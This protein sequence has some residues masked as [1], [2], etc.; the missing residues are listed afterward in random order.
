M[1]GRNREVDIFNLSF[2]DVLANGLGAVVTLLL[3]AF[4]SAPAATDTEERYRKVSD[5]LAKAAGEHEKRQIVIEALKE[6]VK[7]LKVQSDA[8]QEKI[9]GLVRDIGSL[10]VFNFVGIRTKKKNILFL[11]DLSGSMYE[12]P[13]GASSAELLVKVSQSIIK[14]LPPNGCRFN[15]RGFRAPPAGSPLQPFPAWKDDFLLHPATPANRDLAIEAVAA[16]V[17]SGNQGG[18]PTQE[19][20]RRAFQ[21]AS[22]E[23]IIL[24]TDGAPDGCNRR[25]AATGRTEAVPGEI[26]RFLGWVRDTRANRDIEVHC[27]GMGPVLFTD[28]GFRNFLRRLADQNNGTFA[29]F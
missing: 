22:V 18:T 14:T 6:V 15:V 19:A 13:A 11:L 16:I 25:N 3:F 26:D 1:R 27:I 12:G 23:A 29:S 24:I 21:Y 7:D 20:M 28:P 5:E 10:E 9:D 2:L 4:S 8:D 17:S